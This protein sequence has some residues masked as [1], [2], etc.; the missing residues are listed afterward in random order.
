LPC[1]TPRDATA[2]TQARSLMHEPAGQAHRGEQTQTG[3]H[4]GADRASLLHVCEL[5]QQ[6]AP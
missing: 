6:R 1:S 5:L 3:A 2:R 4:W